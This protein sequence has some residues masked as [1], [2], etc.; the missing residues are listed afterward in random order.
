MFI[1]E[2][3]RK[4]RRSGQNYNYMNLQLSLLFNENVVLVM[5]KSSHKPA[6]LEFMSKEERKLKIRSNSKQQALSQHPVE[7]FKALFFSNSTQAE[8][9]A[10]TARGGQEMH[11]HTASKTQDATRQAVVSLCC[12]PELRVGLKYAPRRMCGQGCAANDRERYQ[13]SII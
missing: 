5:Y 13:S 2:S 4:V 6:T 1:E 3:L 7:T 11:I 10:G 12:N 9:I 8:R